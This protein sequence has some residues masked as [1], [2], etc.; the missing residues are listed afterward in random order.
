[1][2]TADKDIT[3]KP[4]GCEVINCLWMDAGVVDYKLC[5]RSYDCEQCP[6]DEV[7]HGYPV[8]G[9]RVALQEH[10]Q[11]GSSCILGCE[12]ASG[13]FYDHGHTWSRVEEGGIVRLGVDDFGQRLLGVAYSLSL[14]QPET[15]IRR[16]DTCCRFTHQA[17]VAA[18]CSPISGKVKATNPDLATRPT[19]VNQD[20][21][22]K[23]WLMLVEPTD[24]QSS[25]KRS[26]YGERVAP[27]LLREI[28]ALRTMVSATDGQS[29]PTLADGGVI[30]KQ[31][32]HGLDVEQTRRLISSFFPVSSSDETEPKS[33][34][35]FSKRR[36]TSW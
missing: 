20:P 15:D 14:P 4:K 30:S 31:F 24:L 23:G 19:L 1:M 35:L 25:L 17:G 5:D 27:W 21:Y 28:E 2:R 36:S 34:I 18:L 26:L 8:K 29:M 6:F 22:G 32:L 3:A 33:A 13:L 11:L 10:M 9:S 7:L 16:G 12:I